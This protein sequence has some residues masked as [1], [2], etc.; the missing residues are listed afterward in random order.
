MDNWQAIASGRRALA[1]QLGE[2]TP[3]QW[4][5][6][7]LC[8]AWTIRDVAAHLILPQTISIPRFL[9]AMAAAGGSFSRANV[10]MTAKQA[11]RSTVDLVADLRRYADSRTTPPGFGSEAPLTEVLVHGQ[12]IRI[13]L[14]LDDPNSTASWAASLGFLVQPKARRGF[15]SRPVGSFRFV[16]SDIDWAHGTGDEVRGPAAALA[17]AILGRRARHD[18][19]TGPG[20]ARLAGA[21]NA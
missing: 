5:V 14:G 20:A 17:L 16:A 10:N 4:K 18:E 13:P 9:V 7:S 2:L 15:V 21:G 1:D 6:A 8:D 3:G 11:Q 19:L 12:D